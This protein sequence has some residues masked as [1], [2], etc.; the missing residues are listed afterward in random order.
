W[1]YSSKQFSFLNARINYEGHEENSIQTFIV[2]D[3][4][5]G[6]TGFR[7]ADSLLHFNIN[8]LA[9]NDG[10]NFRI[11]DLSASFTSTGRKAEIKGLVLKTDNSVINGNSFSIELPN[12]KE[13][14]LEL[15]KF[16]FN[17]SPSSISFYDISLLVP[18][19]KGM[20]QKIDLSGQIHGTLNNLKG[21]DVILS[22]GKS[23]EAVL[24]FYV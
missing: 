11:N 2:Q 19:L 5:F 8:N 21:R 24:D 12:D 6:I 23:T 1:H 9:L 3:F 20:D 10:K 18:E 4:R 16:D 22:T 13:S 14:M 7:Y 15:A 17:F